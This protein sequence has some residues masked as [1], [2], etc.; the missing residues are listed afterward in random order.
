[1]NGLGDELERRT[2]TFTM[3]NHSVTKA[4]TSWHPVTF[5]YDDASAKKIKE[6]KVSLVLSYINTLL[7]HG[8]HCSYYLTASHTQ[9]HYLSY[10]SFFFFFFFCFLFL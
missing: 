7:A 3:W 2:L 1:M 5:D 10:L 9:K 8:T 4:Q 6:I